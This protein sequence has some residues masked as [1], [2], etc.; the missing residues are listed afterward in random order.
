M[1]YIDDSV[2]EAS[3]GNSNFNINIDGTTNLT[4]ILKANAIAT[5]GHYY[6][7]STSA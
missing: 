1:Y 3:T 4:T 7:L 5:K 6:G 2:L